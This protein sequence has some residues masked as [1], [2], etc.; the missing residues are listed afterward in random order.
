[1]LHPC[2]TSMTMIVKSYILLGT[3][4]YADYMICLGEPIQIIGGVPHVNFNLKCRFANFLYKA[5]NSH[6]ERIAF[7]GQIV[8]V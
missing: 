8:H 5:I 4:Q 1:M 7:L 3:L 2:G 6:Y